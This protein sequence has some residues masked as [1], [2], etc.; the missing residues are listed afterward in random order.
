MGSERVRMWP[1]TCEPQ[2]LECLRALEIKLAAA[3]ETLKSAGVASYAKRGLAVALARSS[4]TT[5][6]ISAAREARL[7][8]KSPQH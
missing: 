6:R 4:G 8:R 5:R 7:A 2:T 3:F 1:R